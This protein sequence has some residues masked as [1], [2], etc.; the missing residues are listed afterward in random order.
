MKRVVKREQAKTDLLQHALYIANDNPAAA[1][2][3]LAAA[4]DAFEKLAAM[5]GLG[6]VYGFQ[7]PALADLRFWPIIVPRGRRR[8][9][10]PRVARRN[11]RRARVAPNTLT[12]PGFNCAAR[13]LLRNPAGSLGARARP[14]LCVTD[15]MSRKTPATT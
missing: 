10:D 3:L 12:V 7:T 1:R 15:D 11:G 2:R 5:P 14:W 6:P 9:R 13:V 8:R 4:E